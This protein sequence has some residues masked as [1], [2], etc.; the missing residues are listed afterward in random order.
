MKTEKP[1]QIS[2][3]EW[4]KEFRSNTNV[5]AITMV[6]LYNA[7]YAHEDYISWLEKNQ[8]IT[9]EDLQGNVLVPVSDY[10]TLIKQRNQLVSVMNQGNNRV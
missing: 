6:D 7:F 2:W 4:A 1:K 8:I 5:R 3:V 9:E 10:E